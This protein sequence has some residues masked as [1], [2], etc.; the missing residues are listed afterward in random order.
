MKILRTNTLIKQKWSSFKEKIF[1]NI[2]NYEKSWEY[3]ERNNNVQAAVIDHIP[4]NSA[5]YS[6][7]K[8]HLQPILIH[9][10]KSY[11]SG[12]FEST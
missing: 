3:I 11:Q 5:R 7:N 1:M 6:G 9:H 10:F 8:L 2:D 4:F 12:R